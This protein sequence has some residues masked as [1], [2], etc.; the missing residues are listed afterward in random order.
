M[1]FKNINIKVLNVL[2]VAILIVLFQACTEKDTKFKI[3]DPFSKSNNGFITFND[4]PDGNYRV[5]VRVG[6]DKS[7]GHTVI[8][9][10]SRRMFYDGIFTK[11]GELKDVYFT[12][13]KRD[14]L[15]KEGEVV[16]IKSREINKLNWDSDLTFEFNG[17]SPQIKFIEI[18]SGVVPPSF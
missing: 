8:R 18:A 12:I 7:E 9:G 13:N 17:D 15:I 3:L 2:A 5:H 10:E 4:V 6:S 1:W 16:R 11:K 14:T